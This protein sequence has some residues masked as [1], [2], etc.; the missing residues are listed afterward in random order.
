MARHLVLEDD[1]AE[2]DGHG[3]CDLAHEA[4]GCGRGGDVGRFDRGLQ[5][6]EWGL[7]VRADPDA[8][9]DL[10]DDDP[11]PGGVRGEGDV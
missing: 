6:D 7:E 3:G 4:K 8:G 2:H 10:V 9:D 1:A 5:R 11:R